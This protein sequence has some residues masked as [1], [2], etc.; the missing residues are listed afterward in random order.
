MQNHSYEDEEVSLWR[1]G[2]LGHYSPQQLVNVLFSCV[3]S[4]LLLGVDRRA[5]GTP[6]IELVKKQGNVHS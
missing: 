5:Q 6:Q 1:M 3:V 4:A 2:Q